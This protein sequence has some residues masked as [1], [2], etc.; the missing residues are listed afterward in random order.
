MQNHDSCNDSSGY[1]SHYAIF[2]NAAFNGHKPGVFFGKERN[3][4]YRWVE[5]V[6]EELQFL[7]REDYDVRIT[8]H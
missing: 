7:A 8:D 5:M 2:V 4:I 1:V 3:E 6:L